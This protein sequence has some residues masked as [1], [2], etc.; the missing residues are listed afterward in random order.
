M[1]DARAPKNLRDGLCRNRLIPITWE[2]ANQKHGALHVSENLTGG[3]RPV[4]TCAEHRK[5]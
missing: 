2:N 1:G 3:K 4:K 5:I